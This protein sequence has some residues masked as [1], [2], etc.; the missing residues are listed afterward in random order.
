[1]FR[2]YAG[3]ADS[4]GKALIDMMYKQYPDQ[5]AEMKADPNASP[6]AVG[7]KLMGIAKSENQGSID[8]AEDALQNWFT[9]LVKS[10][11]NFAKDFPTYKEA[12]KAAYSNARARS[13]SKSMDTSRKKKFEKSID[14][15]YGVRG[16]G[17]S[18]PEGGEARMPTPGES[19]LGKALDDQTAIKSF[20][21]MIDDLIPDLR[22]TLSDETRSLFDLIFFDEI[23][24]FGSD[25]DENMNQ[26]SAL[27]EKRPD[28]YKSNEK[29][30]S[31]FV[32]DTR[33]KLLDEI[34]NFIDKH[35]TPDEYE[36]M[37]ETFFADTTP[38]DVR[39]IEKKKIQ[40]KKDEQQGK[41]ERKL[42]R[43]KYEEGQG[44]LDPKDLK[45]YK[46]L[47][48][49]LRDQGVEV[50]DIWPE[51]K[52]DDKKWTLHSKAASMIPVTQIVARIAASLV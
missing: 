34:W 27:K 40:R 44:T 25:V 26:A 43:F 52:P 48:K 22:A 5:V 8:R 19:S 12:L 31:G 51:E 17:G 30:W 37:K 21:D 47:E 1:M 3:V 38:Q 46:N 33:K 35:M 7:N 32:G 39:K 4:F 13:I 10:N 23:G 20:I 6:S 15:T 49:K 36:V 29:R 14:D 28:L 16:E 11:W 45:A 50:D 2:L 41:D 42:A 9:Y 18:D 24:S